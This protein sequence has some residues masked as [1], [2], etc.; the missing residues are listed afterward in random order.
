MKILVPLAAP[1]DA[2]FDP[3]NFHFPKPLVEVA[4]RPMIER[5][6][7][8]LRG[9]SPDARFVF[10]L[11]AED[12]RAFNLDQVA[13]LATDGNADIVILDRPTD[14][15]ACSALMAVDY[16]DEGPLVIANGDQILDFDLRGAV[17][18]FEA[19]G[20]DAGVLTFDSVHP[21]W[22][23]VRTEGSRVIEAA[24]KRPISRNA[25]AGFY[26]FR[27]GG[28]FVRYA[29]RSIEAGRS[30]NGAFYV[31]PTLNE[32]ILDGAQ[33]GAITM[34]DDRYVSFYSPQRIE[35]YE[36][37]MAMNRTERSAQGPLV[38]IPMAGQG[39]RFA[40]AGYTKPKPFIDVLGRPMI[41]QVMENLSTPHADY[42]LLARGEHLEAEPSTVQLLEARG[43][44]QFAVVDR[45]TEG[46]ACT[47]LL[48]REQIDLDRP[49]LIANCDQ[50]IDF[51]CAA[52]IDDCKTR[53]LD[54]SILC[55]RDADRD[56]KW[57]FAKV[58]DNGLVT[59]VKE[60][61]AISDLATVGLYYF[62]RGRDFVKAA[63]DMI[64]RNDRVN[65]EFY[66]CPVYNYAIRNGARIGVY[67]VPAAAMHGIGTPADLDAYLALKTS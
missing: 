58:D 43:D 9:L 62:A 56:P 61:V 60:K 66:V 12:C 8:N 49:I 21:R 38:V 30:V 6:V 55:F 52:F 36:A 39:S 17:R 19:R 40:Q 63:V 50:I 14:G 41:E 35:H 23:Y 67:E 1:N 13:L 2:F 53:G 46:A 27:D 15:A 54:G 22:S 29:M 10:V 44:T 51:D 48:A 34:E 26:Y 28:D 31:A 47:V 32:A 4:G 57:S 7:E 11:R 45:L 25:V 42:L 37:R 16:I 64:A 65:N 5:V 59:E 3:A 33:V 18:T 24:E 20:D